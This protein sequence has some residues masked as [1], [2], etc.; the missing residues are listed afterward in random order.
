LP[1]C[2]CRGKPEQ[3]PESIRNAF[4]RAGEPKRLLEIDGGHYAIY[5]GPGADQTGQAATEWFTEH[6][7]K[8]S[9]TPSTR[10]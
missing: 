8:P 4:A 2:S 6:L 3:A 5:T 1:G 9:V 10:T 7:A